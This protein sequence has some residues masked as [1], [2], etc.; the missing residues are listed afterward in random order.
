MKMK[1]AVLWLFPLLMLACSPKIDRTNVV[2]LGSGLPN[3]L[4]AGKVFF[5]VDSDEDPL[6]HRPY[7]MSSSLTASQYREDFGRA[8]IV[9]NIH[10]TGS[11]IWPTDIRDALILVYDRGYGQS[12]QIE[13]DYVTG[14]AWT[15]DKDGEKS[16]VSQGFV[17]REA[18]G[19]RFNEWS[20]NDP[21]IIKLNEKLVAKGR[22]ALKAGDR[23]SVKFVF[24]LD[25]IVTTH[26]LHFTTQTYALK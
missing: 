12:D 23:I 3:Y 1:K 4:N 14:E 7:N 15:I 25:H 11:Y 20:V 26:I 5:L 6:G 9:G 8:S 21:E 18:A 22:P 16:T 10:D 13:L 24:M 17:K 2:G 19:K